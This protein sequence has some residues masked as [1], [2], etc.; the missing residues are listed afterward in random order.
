[1][2]EHFYD[3]PDRERVGF[4]GAGT[5][6]MYQ[7]KNGIGVHE[8][9]ET[10]EKTE[11]CARCAVHPTGEADHDRKLVFSCPLVSFVDPPSPNLGSVLLRV[12]CAGAPAGEGTRA[13]QAGA[14]GAEVGT[15][16]I[17]AG[18]A[19]GEP[20]GPFVGEVFVEPHCGFADDALG[21][22]PREEVVLAFDIGAAS[23]LARGCGGGG[24]AGGPL[25][26]TFERRFEL[27]ENCFRFRLRT[28]LSGRWR[29]CRRGCI[30]LRRWFV[31]GLCG[32]C[33]RWSPN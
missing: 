3:C 10:H 28:R 9:R 20:L 12:R 11:D 27:L 15:A 17:D 21:D 26:S 14:E 25:T 1:M 5:S 6:E 22:D 18:G 30:R 23:G 29:R 32:H 24:A 13:A 16:G 31:L 4:W 2:R 7:P 8:R 19:G 33:S